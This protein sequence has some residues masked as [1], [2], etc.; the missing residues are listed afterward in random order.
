MKLRNSK[1]M[2]SKKI[3]ITVI[4]LIIIALILMML[5]DNLISRKLKAATGRL[6]LTDVA[7]IGDYVNYDPTAGA[8]VTSENTSYTSNKGSTEVSGNGSKDGQAFSAEAYKNSGGKWRIL[9]IDSYGTI[10]LI[11][12]LIYKDTTGEDGKKVMGEKGL[13]FSDALG[14]LWAEEEIHKVCAI[15]GR[16]EGADTSKTITYYYGGPYDQDGSI[17]ANTIET[18]QGRK[19][20]ISLNSGARGLTVEDIDKISGIES[21][22]NINYSSETVEKNENNAKYFPTLMGDNLTGRSEA[23]SNIAD[24]YYF[25]FYKYT[26][27]SKNVDL[28]AREKQNEM[29]KLGNTYWLASRCVCATNE[30]GRFNIR[31]VYRDGKVNDIY[32][33]C[34][35]NGESEALSTAYPIRAI[36][37]LQNG[38]KTTDAQYNPNTGWNI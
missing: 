15:Y 12:D 16:G 17:T 26:I 25:T 7:A 6:K 8:N 34:I 28:S 21:T 4:L 22:Y 2:V 37:T 18:Q 27:D 30:I 23:Q 1:G 3:I 29:L 20:T 38:I 32:T 33:Y 19:K 35:D 36:V 9:D 10:T 31:T 5:T 14:Y 24:G 11:S 13:E